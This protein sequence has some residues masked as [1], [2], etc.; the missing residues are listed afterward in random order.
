MTNEGYFRNQPSIRPG[1]NLEMSGNGGMELNIRM[2]PPVAGNVGELNAHARRGISDVVGD[3]TYSLVAGMLGTHKNEEILARLLSNGN[4]SAGL[5]EIA[6]IR[7]L[8]L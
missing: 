1:L 8:T 7:G 6:T 2:C 3:E 5:S 4:Y